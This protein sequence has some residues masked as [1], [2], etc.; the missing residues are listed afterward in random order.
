MIALSA[1]W[2][3]ILLSAVGVFIASNIL[4][5]ALPFWH[6]GDYSA[7]PN[8]KAALDAVR[9]AKSAQYM[10]P[11][12]DYG[13]MT[14]EQ[15]EEAMKQPMAL[16]I[17]RNP[18]RFSF[19][20]ALIQYFIYTLVLSFL[21]AYVPAV[22]LA[23]GTPWAKVFQVAG[24][25]GILGFS[26]GTVTDSIWYGKPWPITIKNII[27]GVIYGLLSGAIFGWLWPR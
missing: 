12:F 21:I 19:P 15:R 7:L 23:P 8:E 24:T 22:T 27:D 26:F 2:L 17:L 20:A 1:L 25:A 18:A 10:I 9:D 4:W 16:M 11:R 5:M 3:P 13:K 14:A 6:R